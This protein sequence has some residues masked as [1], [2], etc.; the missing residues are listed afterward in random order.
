MVRAPIIPNFLIPLRRN[1]STKA[2]EPHSSY[3]MRPLLRPAL[4]A[5]RAA[6]PDKC[7]PFM[8]LHPSV[9]Q[10]SRGSNV[11][12]RVFVCPTN[13]SSIKCSQFSRRNVIS[14]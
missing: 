4:R 14:L 5:A 1:S 3:P 11:T 13:I 8:P 6:P 12:K 9:A 7:L 10:T 2:L